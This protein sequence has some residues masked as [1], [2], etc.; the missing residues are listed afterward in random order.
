MASESIPVIDCSPL[1]SSAEW[2]SPMCSAAIAEIHAAF[3]TWGVF[4]LTGTNAIP[5]AL[6]N[7]TRDVLTKFFSLPLPRKM[8]LHLKDGGWAWRGYMPWGGEGTKGNIDQKEGFYGGPELAS[9]DE[10]PLKGMP[11]FGENQ[12]PDDELP[13]MRHLVLEYIEKVTQLG[14]TISDA[15]SLGLGLDQREIKRRL[16]DPKPIQLFRS[17]KYYRKPG[18]DS[19]G[20]GEHSD[21]G[22]LTILSQ[23]ATGLQ[24]LSPSKKW[25]DVPLIPDSYVVNVGDILDR[26]TLGVYISPLH[27]VLPPEPNSDRL[28]IPFFFDPAWN[29]EVKPLPLPGRGDKETPSSAARERWNRNSTFKDLQ[30]IWGQYLGVKVQKIFPDL[31]LPE[32]SAVTRPSGRH[33]VEIRR[34]EP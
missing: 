8:A 1:F 22:F 24:M 32:F 6:A 21:F 25:V 4:I 11:T 19:C 17:F 33:L 14:L 3:C 12:F 7:K 5:P 10:H 13:E 28:S 29:A 27:R 23:N 34:E 2:D 16:L 15:I 18:V 31:I 9:D 20:I 30:G 26:L